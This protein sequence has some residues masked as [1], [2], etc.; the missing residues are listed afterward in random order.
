MRT[1]HLAS[2]TLISALLLACSSNPAKPTPVPK[3][4]ISE[5]EKETVAHTT[6]EAAEPEVQPEPAPEAE[7][8]PEPKPEPTVEENQERGSFIAEGKASFYGGKFHGRKTASGAI[9]NQHAMT[10]AHPTLPFG[11]RVRVTH[12]RNGRS[13]VVTIND[14]GPFVKTRII[15]VSRAAAEQLGMVQQG[16]AHVR[17]ERLP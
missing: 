17:V 3:P 8:E 13:V 2:L 9:F 4:V 12:V 7:P 14:R 1:T 10:A 11:T 6:E 15:D 16:V 5:A